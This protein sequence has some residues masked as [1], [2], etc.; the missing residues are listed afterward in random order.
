[1]ISTLAGVTSSFGYFVE[2]SDEVYQRFHNSINFLSYFPYSGFISGVTR[3]AFALD[4]LRKSHSETIRIT[5]VTSVARGIFEMAFASY[6]P[7]LGIADTVITCL[8]VMNPL[9]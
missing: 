6:R 7:Y 2:K 3:T 5:L 9:E 4:M 1:M 8:S